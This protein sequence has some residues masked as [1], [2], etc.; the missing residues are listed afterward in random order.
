MSTALLP[1]ELILSLWRFRFCES[2]LVNT[3][4]AAM[5]DLPA[6][7]TAVEIVDQM[8]TRWDFDAQIGGLL[9]NDFRAPESILGD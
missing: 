5:Y 9:T 1:R 2:C 6:K 4:R 7:D 8:V 3:I